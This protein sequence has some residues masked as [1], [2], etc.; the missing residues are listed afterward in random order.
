MAPPTPTPGKGPELLTPFCL[1]GAVGPGASGCPT[2]QH[3]GLGLS[4][5]ARAPACA[6]LS[7]WP[8]WLSETLS[9]ALGEGPQVFCWGCPEPDQAPSAPTPPVASAM[10]PPAMRSIP[11]QLAI[12]LSI[13][14]CLSIML[15]QSHTP[16]PFTSPCGKTTKGHGD[17]S[18]HK[19]CAAS[20]ERGKLRQPGADANLPR[21]KMPL[22]AQ[23]A[24]QIPRA[25]PASSSTL[26]QLPAA[27]GPTSQPPHP[28]P[29]GLG[30]T[31]CGSAR[32][33]APA[34]RAAAPGLLA[35]P[36]R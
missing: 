15:S 25:V 19:V 27:P 7:L 1:L 14:L 20:W 4:P 8:A 6:V 33:P 24:L 22:G 30:S 2:E 5:L 9:P 35:L 17:P 28:L 10:G 34:Q 23:L 13:M 26:A 31:A 36:G 29:Q 32:Q 12:L 3:G 21:R 18:E 11:W 16:I